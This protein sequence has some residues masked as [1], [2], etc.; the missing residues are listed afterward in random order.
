MKNTQQSTG[1]LILRLSIGGLMLLHGFAKLTHGIDGIVNM[2]ANKGVPSFIAYGV[3]LGE[4]VAP[5]MIIVGYR[6]RLAAAVYV[7]NML[8]ILFMAHSEDVFALSEHGGWK[9]ELVGLYLFGSL[10]LFF[11]GAGKYALSSGKRWD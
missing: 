1:L 5:L 11:T 3:Y 7:I 2:L 4:I 8:V 6:T 9:A 10:A